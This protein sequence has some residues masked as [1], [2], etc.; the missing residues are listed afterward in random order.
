MV[1]PQVRRREI[2]LSAGLHHEAAGLDFKA[3]IL[4][5][6]RQPGEGLAGLKKPLEKIIHHE[7][8]LPLAVFQRT[9]LNEL[10]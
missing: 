1:L 6:V 7:P 4:L 9:A 3:A 2:S 10:W 8:E 5:A